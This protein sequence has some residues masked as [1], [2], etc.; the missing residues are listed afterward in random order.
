MSSTVLSQA[1]ALYDRA[2]ETQTG[3]PT[4]SRTFEEDLA[5]FIHTGR[6]Y[7]T[8]TC[9]LFAKAVP[10][11]RE[12]HEPWDTWEPHECDAWLVWLAA[13]DLAEFFQY[14]PY[15]LPWLV[16][17]RRDRLRK[18]PYDLA[19]RHILQE[20]ATAALETPS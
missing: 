14:V 10:S 7:I 9:V 8:P 6:V 12:Y 18:W 11:H 5:A 20:H 19:R 4:Q 13:G 17:A 16:W 2:G 1:L 15:E 3:T